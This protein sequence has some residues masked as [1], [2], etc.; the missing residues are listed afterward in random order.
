[1][2]KFKAVIVLLVVRHYAACY[3]LHI[4]EYTN[5]MDRVVLPF[6][7]IGKNIDLG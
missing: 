3:I 2:L 6:A 5:L 1:M 4:Q 7:M